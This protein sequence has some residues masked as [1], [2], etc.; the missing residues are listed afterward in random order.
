MPS[1]TIHRLL[2]SY[3]R[4]PLLHLLP[5]AVFAVL[6]VAYVGNIESRYRADGVLLVEGQTF[7]SSLT[8][9]RGADSG[10]ET[11]ASRT[12]RQLNSLLQ[13]DAFMSSVVANSELADPADLGAGDLQQLRGSIGSWE[14]GENLVQVWSSHEQAEVAF[15]LAGATIETLIDWQ[16]DSEVDQSTAAETFL[17]PLTQQ[18]REE[19]NAAQSELE[20]YLRANPGPAE[21]ERPATQQIVVDRLT[22]EVSGASARYADAVAKEENAR[23]ATAQVESDVM[24]RLQLIDEPQLPTAPEGSFRATL[25]SLA[26]FLATGGLLTIAAIIA[27]AAADQTVRFPQDVR[28]RFDLDIVAVLPDASAWSLA[29]SAGDKAG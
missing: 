27:G 11:P 8:Q 26:A 7:L 18:Y 28:R 13:T 23:L 20:E 29:P 16:I 5:L 10:W 3:F 17:S 6:G 4:H 9:V 1:H 21:G 24:S 22:A 19:L 25:V 12:S 15:R 14:A 2:D